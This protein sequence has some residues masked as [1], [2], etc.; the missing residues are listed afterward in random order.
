MISEQ[1]Y[2]DQV[3]AEVEAEVQAND[4]ICQRFE[5]IYFVSK[6][7]GRG[8]KRKHWEEIE[9]ITDRYSRVTRSWD[10]FPFDV[11]ASEAFPHLPKDLV[12]EVLMYHIRKYA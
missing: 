7:K 5:Y 12:D 6:S 2:Q 4:P 9:L 8:R 3:E 10:K 1:E 11:Y